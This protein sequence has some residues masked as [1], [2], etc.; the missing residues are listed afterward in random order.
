MTD[1]QQE[2]NEDSIIDYQPSDSSDVLMICQHVKCIAVC[3]VSWHGMSSMA[4]TQIIAKPCAVKT[5]MPIF[6]YASMSGWPHLTVRQKL[7]F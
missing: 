1:K 3:S 2:N 7:P 6:Q 4:E 5:D